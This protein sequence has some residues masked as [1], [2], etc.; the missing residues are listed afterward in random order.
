MKVDVISKSESDGEVV[1][2]IAKQFA[3]AMKRFLDDK[4]YKKHKG[5]SSDYKDQRDKSNKI[6]IEKFQIEGDNSLENKIQCR[7]CLRYSHIQA[8]CGNTLKKKKEKKVFTAILS[9]SE[10]EQEI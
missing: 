3:K 9:D 7:E 4:Q 2:L 10:S 6:R 5:I 8:E 1:A